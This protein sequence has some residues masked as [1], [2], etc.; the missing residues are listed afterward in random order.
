MSQGYGPK[1]VGSRGGHWVILELY[2]DGTRSCF[3]GYSK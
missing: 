3:G 2:W 1:G